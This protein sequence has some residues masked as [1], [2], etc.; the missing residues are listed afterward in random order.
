MIRNSGSSQDCLP[1][2]SYLDA[3]SSFLPNLNDRRAS[4]DYAAY[5]SDLIRNHAI[6]LLTLHRMFERAA[7]EYSE[8]NKHNG[9]QANACT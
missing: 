3:G 1:Q 2:L 9:G 7:V 8:W 5:E 6:V 4:S